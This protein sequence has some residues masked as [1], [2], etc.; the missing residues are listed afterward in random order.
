MN[1]LKIIYYFYFMLFK[2]IELN[3]CMYTLSILTLSLVYVQ[4]GMPYSN[5]KKYYIYS[6]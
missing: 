1:T 4:V 3:S 6:S 2:S 5:V